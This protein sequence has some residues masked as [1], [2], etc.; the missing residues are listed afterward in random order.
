MDPSFIPVEVVPSKTP[1]GLD[2]LR[3][4]YKTSLSAE[5]AIAAAPAVGD[6]DEVFPNMFLMPI[7]TPESAESATRVDL[8]Y[9][10]T[11][12]EDLPASK[13]DNENA[14]QSASSSYGS[15]GG[16][17]SPVTIQFYA[18][19]TVLT[20]FSAGA[21]GTT[22]PA[23][24]TDDPVI[25]TVSLG[26]ADF[27]P[28]SLPAI[29]E[30]YFSLQIVSTIN[31]TEIVPGQYW[32][33]T[34]RKTKVYVPYV[35]NIVPGTAVIQLSTPGSFYTVGDTLSIAGGGGSATLVLTATG[36]SQSVVAW[37][38]SSNTFTT[39]QASLAAS[40]GSGSGATFNVLIF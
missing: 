25:I 17:A 34:A 15:T 24:P 14:V 36:V 5:D 3:R 18:P 22:A 32:Q 38:V 29:T 27:S 37:T 13:H 12:T 40:G 21:P 28:A 1:F 4:S 16:I 39:P 19:S 8:V 7:S 10:G 26:G 2:Q 33:N 30:T 23:D 9:M 31:S 6:V 20:Y 35:V 11:F